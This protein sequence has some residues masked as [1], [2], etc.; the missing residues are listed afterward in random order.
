MRERQMWCKPRSKCDLFREMPVRITNSSI[1][2]ISPSKSHVWKTIV[3]VARTLLIMVHFLMACTK[4]GEN[5]CTPT[6]PECTYHSQLR[7]YVLTAKH[8][9]MT[10]LATRTV[11]ALK[12]RPLRPFT[13]T[14]RSNTNPTEGRYKTRSATTKPVRKNRL[15]AGIKGTTRIAKACRV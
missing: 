2:I 13:P 10:R 6:R 14:I 11:R 9:T 15:E 7:W 1:T 3:R 8:I 4:T 5:I 12:I